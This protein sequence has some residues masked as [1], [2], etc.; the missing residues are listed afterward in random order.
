MTPPVLARL[1]PACA[2]ALALCLAGCDRE[3]PRAPATTRTIVL[4]FDG[5]DPT[6]AERWMAEGRLPNFAALRDAGHFQRLGT[7]NPP[8][9]PV[10]WASF[11]TGHGPGHHGIFDFLRRSPGAYAIDFSIAEQ[12][13]ARHVMPLFGYRIPLGEGEL[14]NRRKGEPFWVT[15]ERD[16]QRATVLRVPVTYPPDPV[17]GMISGMGVP[18]LL[19]T[20][21]T[22]TLLA[23]RRLAGAENGG[24]ILLAPV[25]ADGVVRT[26]LEGP[27]HPLKPAAP[28]LSVPLSLSP[29]GRDG[30]VLEIDGEPMSLRVGEWS[31]WLRVRFDM[32]VLGSVPGMLRAHLRDGFPRPLLYLS[33]I[34]ADPLEPALPVSSPADYAAELAGRIGTFHTLG[35]PEETW[36]LDQGHLDEAAWLDLVRTTLAEGEAML[37]DALDRRDS[38][39]VMEVFVQPDRVSHMFW[40]GFDETHPLYPQ[41]SEL[42]R[43][44][45]PW[46]YAEADRVLG[47]VRRRMGPEDRLVVLSDHG[48]APYRRSV[49]LNRWLA[50]RGLLAF[51][52]DADPSAPLFASVDWSKT[53]AY[54]LGLNGIFINRRGREPE[55]IVDAAQAAT[56]KSNLIDALRT[57]RDPADEAEIVVQAYD[58]EQ[59]YQGDHAADAPDL[60]VGYARGYRASWQ[61]SLGST[62]A[63]L[64][65]DNRQLWSGDHCIDPSLV[66]GVLFTSFKPERAID[67]IGAIAEIILGRSPPAADG[68]RP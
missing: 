66:P 41:T 57:M 35:M 32:G 4:G 22:Y 60:V 55:G 6:L 8:Q 54:A 53:Q 48:F 43:G 7:S 33:P 65:E 67:D 49:H 47:E 51:K 61:T 12:E 13:P 24:R 64:V 58:G 40:R 34:Q 23:T 26:R 27:P 21:G 30:A 25:D 42:A 20:Q 46:I 63:E 29:E 3:A 56:L 15:A 59:I 17:H 44:A 50:D 5:M 18:D 52:P 39:L 38:E 9:S 1:L 36:A 45:I 10:A 19:G 31:P 28:A 68:H 11:A 37:Y 62:P 16:G 2:A 14:R